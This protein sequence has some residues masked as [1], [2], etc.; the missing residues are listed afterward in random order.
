MNRTNTLQIVAALWGL[1]VL[2][3]CAF[4]SLDLGSLMQTQPFE[5]R[6]LKEGSKD[7]ILVIEVLRHHHHNKCE[8]QLLPQSGDP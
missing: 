3:G 6:V 8:R 7:K 4:V 1:F 2:Q 5:E